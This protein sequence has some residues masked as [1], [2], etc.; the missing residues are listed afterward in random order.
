[1]VRLRDIAAIPSPDELTYK[2]WKN[3]GYGIGQYSHEYYDKERNLT[4][5]QLGLRMI[6]L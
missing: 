6:E 5:H 1:M 2:A 3:V 4:L